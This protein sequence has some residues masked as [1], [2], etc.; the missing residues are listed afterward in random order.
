MYLIYA[1]EQDALDRSEQEAILRNHSYHVV[2]RGT[3]YVTAPQPTAS[4]DYA[5][6]VDGFDLTDEERAS[7]VSKFTPLAVEEE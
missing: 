2:G 3:R 4:G 5:L 6:L 1:T 7:A